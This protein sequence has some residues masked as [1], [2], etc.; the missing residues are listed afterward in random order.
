MPPVLLDIF[1]PLLFLTSSLAPEFSLVLLL[2]EL[3][4]LVIFAVIRLPLEPEL[5]PLP[6][7]NFGTVEAFI[8]MGLE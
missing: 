3:G 5:P 6:E 2:V 7:V 8:V 4:G 1:R